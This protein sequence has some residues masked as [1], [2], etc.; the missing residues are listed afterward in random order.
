MLCYQ[1]LKVLIAGTEAELQ[2]RE[3]PSNQR[4][5]ERSQGPIHRHHCWLAESPRLTAE[6]DKAVVCSEARHTSALQE[7]Q[8]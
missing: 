8:S 5:A 1:T 2:V 3:T 6:L 4:T 7:P